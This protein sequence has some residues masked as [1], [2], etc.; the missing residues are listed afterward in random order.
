M[1]E[2]CKGKTFTCIKL[3]TLD[4]LL[5]LI[6]VLRGVAVQDISYKDILKA[7]LQSNSSYSCFSVLPTQCQK[8]ASFDL[9][10]FLRGCEPNFSMKSLHITFLYGTA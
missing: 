5:P 10:L 8:R 6:F 9:N 1:A 2:T 3:V 7:E 4:G